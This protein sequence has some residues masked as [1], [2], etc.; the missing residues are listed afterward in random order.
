MHSGGFEASESGISFVGEI[1][2]AGHDDRRSA[3]FQQVNL[4]RQTWVLRLNF[5]QQII[6]CPRDAVA[7]RLSRDNDVIVSEQLFD[8]ARVP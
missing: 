1:N 8:E 5:S 4:A 6:N 2:D 7:F 3:V